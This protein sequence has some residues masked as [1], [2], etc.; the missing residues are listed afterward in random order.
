MYVC[1]Y[2]YICG[3][4]ICMQY[5]MYALVFRERAK[6]RS[7]ISPHP[8]IYA[9]RWGRCQEA[10]GE[11]PHLQAELGTQYVRGLQYGPDKNHLE[12][13]VRLCTNS[14]V[15]VIRMLCMSQSLG[16]GRPNN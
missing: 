14:Y 15:W 2:V 16:L 12:A 4:Y 5:Y 13:I 9:A 3:V 8:C 10:Y 1:V 7:N 6:F 11:D